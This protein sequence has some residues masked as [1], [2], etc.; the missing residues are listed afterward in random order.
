[1]CA[2]A[3]KAQQHTPQGWHSFRVS[4]HRAGLLPAR[5]GHLCSGARW[6]ASGGDGADGGGP[7][8][9]H[10]GAGPATCQSYRG[11]RRGPEQR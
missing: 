7:R 3:A 2:Q 6:T 10:V 1:E 9:T 5:P 4:H 8:T 11:G